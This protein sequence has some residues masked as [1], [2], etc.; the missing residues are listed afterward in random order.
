MKA[1]VMTTG[2]VFGLLV[3]VHLWRVVEEG[4]R[5]LRDPWYVGVTLLAALLCGWAV[6]L[7]RGLRRGAPTGS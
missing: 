3:A 6:R 2:M 4:A 5:P 1:Y 7:W